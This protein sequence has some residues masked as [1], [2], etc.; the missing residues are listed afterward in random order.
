LL[1]N[2]NDPSDL[3]KLVSDQLPQL[4]SEIREFF[5]DKI[6]KNGGHFSANLGVVELTVALHYLFDF[7]TDRLIWD[8]GHQAYIHKLLTGR[9]K[10]FNHIRKLGG[11]AGF[12]KMSESEYDHF[13]TGHSSTSISAILG[14]AEAA[15]LDNKSHKHIAIIG[16]GSLTGGMAFEALNNLGTSNANVLVIINDNQIG[17]DPNSGAINHH[18]NTINENINFFKTLGLEYEGPIDGHDLNELI[19][20]LEKSIA[21]SSPK[22]LHIRTVKGKGYLPAEKA[23][24]D[25]HSVSYVKIDPSKSKTDNPTPS[26]FQDVFGH[27]LLELAEKDPRIVGI[28]PAMPSGSSMKIL[29]DA[30]PHRVF[31][32]GIAEQHAVTFSAGLALAGKRPFCS[33]YSSFAQRAYDQIIHDVA[34]QNIPVVFCIDRAGLVGADGP[35]HH[36]SF[37]IAYLNAIPNLTIISPMDEHELRNAMYWAVDYTDGPIVIRYPRGLG[38]KT[39]YKNEIQPLKI[40]TSRILQKGD[41]IGIISIG[42]IGVEVQKAID[43]SGIQKQIHHIDA[44]FIKPIDKN[45]VLNMLQTFDH[46]ITVEESC[47]I[48][49][50]GQQIKTI[51]QDQNYMGRITSLGLPDQF[52]EQ[53]TREELR[54]K[55]NLDKDGICQLIQ[56][57]IS[58]K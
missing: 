29:M 23:Q 56:A 7:K 41:K 40:G 9:K 5:I 53:G 8:V 54:A 57:I 20:S 49:G 10:E 27:T 58:K 33:I 48:G 17:I 38:S 35:T 37:D 11:L 30:M 14:M 34:L 45:E 44:R 51:A 16:D 39:K 3:K 19:T 28:T 26:K 18:L 47:L 4:C 43:K 46:I 21:I 36:G 50:F 22:I 31:D 2:I 6:L 24:T 13:G 55:Y 12:P 32:V 42:E 25:W 1:H 52:I 15:K